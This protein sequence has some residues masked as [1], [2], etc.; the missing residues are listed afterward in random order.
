MEIDVADFSDSQKQAFLDLLVLAMYADGKLSSVEDEL[1]QQ[2]L[3]S[4]VIFA[5][6]FIAILGNTVLR[7]DRTVESLLIVRC[8]WVGKLPHS[9]GRRIGC[10][11]GE[12]LP[13]NRRVK[14][15]RCFQMISLAGI[16]DEFHR[17]CSVGISGY[18]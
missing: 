9:S 17:H 15:G 1:L 7:R 12:R 5:S 18:P 4:I 10:A 16:A 3:T 11:S 2:V 14:I 6:I 8:L 13:N